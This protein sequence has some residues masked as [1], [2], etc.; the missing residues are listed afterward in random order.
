MALGMLSC[1]PPLHLFYPLKGDY[2]FL[3]VYDVDYYDPGIRN[4]INA[5][6]Y[7]VSSSSTTASFACIQLKYAGPKP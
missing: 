4:D 7:E 1:D 3:G 6:E 5:R 2:T